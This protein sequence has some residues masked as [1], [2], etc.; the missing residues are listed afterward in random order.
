MEKEREKKKD[1]R[2]DR[3]KK[4][5]REMEVTGNI[6]REID[7]KAVLKKKERERDR[8]KR[9]Y[10][11]IVWERKRRQIYKEVIKTEEERLPVFKIERKL[12]SR[13]IN[14]PLW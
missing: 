11:Y 2:K 3:K 12:I 8:I 14:R 13:D 5:E 1:R 4:K 9:Q 10:T 7:I 6:D